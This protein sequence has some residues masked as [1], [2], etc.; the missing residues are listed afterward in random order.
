MSP[1]TLEKRFTDL[2]DR[3]TVLQDATN[4]LKELIDRLTNFNFQPGSVPVGVG[5]DDNVCSELSS[6]IN[7]ILREQEEELE[8]LQEEIIDIR[9]GKPSSNLQHDKDRL[10][11]GASRL[12]QELQN[13]R[14]AFR[15]AQMSAKRNLQLAQRRERELLYASFLNQRSGASSPAAAEAAISIPS[16][17]K[18]PKRSE[19]SKEDQMISASNDVTESMR[20]AHDLMAAE[21]SKSDFAHNTLKESTTSLSQLSENYSS[22]DTMLS[23]SRAL[24]GTLL[25]SQKTDTWYLQSA[26]YLLIVTIGWLIFRRLLWG[27]TWWLIWLPLK[28]VFRS[29]V[30]VTNT[31]SRHTSQGV[32]SNLDPAMMQSMSQLA[33]MNNEGVPTVHVAQP[34]QT[35]RELSESTMEEVNEVINEADSVEEYPKENDTGKETQEGQ[36]EETL[37]ERKDDEPPNPKKRMMEEDASNQQDDGNEGGGRIRDEL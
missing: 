34:S 16:R 29:A 33:Q 11:D 35:P 28:L 23:N 9:P 27:P 6:E 17:R 5:D 3:L 20:R 24:L 25:K 14:I 21:L 4:Q 1:N 10:K 12:G 26:F 22:L 7:Q 30:G 8:L 13:C 36:Q 32:G 19:M 18:P 31:V 15:R 2:Q 37:R